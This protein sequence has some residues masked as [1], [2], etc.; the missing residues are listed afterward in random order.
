MHYD[1]IAV[2]ILDR[3]PGPALE[4]QPSSR[5]GHRLV[6]RKGWGM[7]VISCLGG[8]VSRVLVH[9]NDLGM[10]REEIEGQSSNAYVYIFTFCLQAQ[11]G[12]L[13]I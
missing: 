5:W 3:G 4:E 7:Y 12:K 9:G 10:S 1:R 11:L 2:R 13:M 6:P 8:L